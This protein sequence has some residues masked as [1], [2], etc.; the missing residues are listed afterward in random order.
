MPRG[1]TLFELLI[2][3]LVFAVL[4][5]A[6]G[7]VMNEQ[8]RR[9]QMRKVAGA[10]SQIYN[11]ARSEAVFRNRRLYIHVQ[12]A[13]T[14][15][16][17]WMLRLSDNPVGELSDDK[18]IQL[19]RGK[20]VVLMPSAGGGDRIKFDGRTGKPV[21]SGH[22]AFYYPGLPG[23]ILHMKYTSHTGRARVCGIQ[24]SWYGYVQC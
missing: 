2:T 4:A 14:P 3:L 21:N 11:L 9:Y 16:Q 24:G 23:K 17:T 1:F 8:Y 20:G 10:L 5:L 22:L 6:G 18:A 13:V 7:P 15:A 12:P 19:I